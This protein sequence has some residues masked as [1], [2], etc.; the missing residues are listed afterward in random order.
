M[1]RR[2][3]ARIRRMT[4]AGEKVKER[5]KVKVPERRGIALQAV[6]SRGERARGKEKERKRIK[7]GVKAKG[8]VEERVEARVRGRI[9]TVP[10]T[11][12]EAGLR[13]RED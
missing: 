6:R 1:I 2:G 7:K 9:G 13:Q 5:A 8:R 3:R 11:T 4:K 10:K 12:P